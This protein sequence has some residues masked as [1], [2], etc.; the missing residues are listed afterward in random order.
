MDGGRDALRCLRVGRGVR[1]CQRVGRERRCFDIYRRTATFESARR[2]EGSARGGVRVCQRAGRGFQREAPPLRREAAGNGVP[3]RSGD[4]CGQVTEVMAQPQRGQSLL[5]P[6]A[7]V[8]PQFEQVQQP[9]T[10]EV[11]P[12]A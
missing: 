9:E 7:Q 12:Q 6:E 3:L 11:V 8:V 2:R 1:V 10:G 4:G 5:R